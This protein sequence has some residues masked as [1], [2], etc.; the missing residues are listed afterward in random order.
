ML[1]ASTMQKGSKYLRLCRIAAAEK[2]EWPPQSDRSQ[3][4]C[5]CCNAALY[6]TILGCTLCKMEEEEEEE[7]VGQEE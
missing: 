2:K 5:F 6:M 4:L 3:T 7:E 1:P